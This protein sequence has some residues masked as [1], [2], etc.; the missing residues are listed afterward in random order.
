MRRSEALRKGRLPPADRAAG[1]PAAGRAG[2][3]VPPGGHPGARTGGGRRHPRIRHRGRGAGAAGGHPRLDPVRAGRRSRRSPRCHGGEP[4][5][6]RATSASPRAGQ[7]GH[8]RIAPTASGTNVRGIGP[9]SRS[10]A[11]H[12]AA[13][14]RGHRAGRAG[15]SGDPPPGRQPSPRHRARP[16]PHDVPSAALDAPVQTPASLAPTRFDPL[17]RTMRCDGMQGRSASRIARIDSAK[18]HPEGLVRSPG[19]GGIRRRGP[20]RARRVADAPMTAA[21][22]R[23]A[24]A[25]EGVLAAAATPV[26]GG[27]APSPTSRDD[28]DP[29]PRSGFACDPPERKPAAS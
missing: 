11:P 19:G 2:R 15:Q 29:T 25:T 12:R 26:T 22:G 14:R 20:H 27:V 10:P 23:A 1:R 21:G 28:D 24:M 7:P 17:G 4:S 18:A 13:G 9:P 16:R 6:G 3:G 8:A 5:G